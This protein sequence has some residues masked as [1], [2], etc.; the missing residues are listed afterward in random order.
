MKGDPALKVFIMCVHCV[1]GGKG[2]GARTSPPT[3]GIRDPLGGGGVRGGCRR[4]TGNARRDVT[5]RS[6]NIC[7]GIKKKLLN[8]ISVREAGGTTVEYL[9]GF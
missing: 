2:G 7:K 6:K 3:K 5:E 1:G 9:C 8:L 4:Q